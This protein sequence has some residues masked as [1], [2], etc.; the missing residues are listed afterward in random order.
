MPDRMLAEGSYQAAVVD[1]LAA[2][3]ESEDV[4]V[5]K[6]RI[7]GF[8][9]TIM[10]SVLKSHGMFVLPTRPAAVVWS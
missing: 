6:H 4:V 10:D 2:S 7:S 1:P 8:F 3:M 9:D 5:H